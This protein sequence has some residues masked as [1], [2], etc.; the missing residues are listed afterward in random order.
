MP[1]PVFLCA[2]TSTEKLMA[3]FFASFELSEP[4][5]NYTFIMDLFLFFQK[6]FFDSE[7][8]GNQFALFL[9]VALPS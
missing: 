3:H 8:G 4:L 6:E 1:W 5:A 2:M 7:E 9:W